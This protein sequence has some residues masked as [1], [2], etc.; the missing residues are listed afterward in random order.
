ML[1][2]AHIVTKWAGVRPKATQRDPMI[3]YLPESQSLFVATGG[4]KISYGIAHRIAQAACER[5]IGADQ[6]TELPPTFE[7]VNHL[8]QGV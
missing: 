1:K 7:T 4:F 8:K 6:L 2:D 3:G 5:L